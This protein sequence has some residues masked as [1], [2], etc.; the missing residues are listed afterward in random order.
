MNMNNIK[1]R[2]TN[3]E[4]ISTGKKDMNGKEIF[5]GDGLQDITCEFLTYQIRIRKN[6]FVKHA[7]GCYTELTDEN[8]MN[9][10]ITP[11][12]NLGMGAT[13]FK[14]NLIV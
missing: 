9:C 10:K 4:K 14:S 3:G 2:L 13:L 6:M 7:G 5:L 12:V 1:A 11:S 8:I